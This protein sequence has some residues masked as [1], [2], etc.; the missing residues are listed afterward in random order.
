MKVLNIL[1][2]PSQDARWIPSMR[3]LK[4]YEGIIIIWFEFVT[5]IEAWTKVAT[6][7]GGSWGDAHKNPCIHYAVN[8]HSAR[9]SIDWRASPAYYRRSQTRSS[10]LLPHAGTKRPWAPQNLNV[11]QGARKLALEI[12]KEPP[13]MPSESQFH[14]FFLFRETGSRAN[15]LNTLLLSLFYL[16]APSQLQCL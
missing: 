16:S 13:G 4:T 8:R 7:K 5:C 15:H 11:S 3:F 1:R 6:D 14:D 10:I 9:R 12:R 2:T